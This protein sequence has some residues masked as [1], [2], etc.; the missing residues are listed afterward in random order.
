MLMVDVVVIDDDVMMMFLGGFSMRK[1]R[2]HQEILQK[3]PCSR[4][5]DGQNMSTAKNPKFGG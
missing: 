2:G 3:G 5:E 1:G 4:V